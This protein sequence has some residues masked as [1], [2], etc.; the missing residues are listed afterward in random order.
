MAIA[1]IRKQSIA[2]LHHYSHQI[3]HHK[4]NQV[5]CNNWSYLNTHFHKQQQQYNVK[6]YSTKFTNIFRKS[7]GKVL[8]VPAP[9]FLCSSTPSRNGLGLG[10]GLVGWYLG[11][12]KSR[13]VLTKSVTSSLI[14]IAAD[15]T[16]QV[17]HSSL[18]FFLFVISN[19]LHFILPFCFLNDRL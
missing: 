8:E 15:L 17:L 19:Y 1:L 9:P 11:M 12:I 2:K 3:K 16:S 10:P 14:Y 4:R 6:C 18:P 5:L 7:I 13:P